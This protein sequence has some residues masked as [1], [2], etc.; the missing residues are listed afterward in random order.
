MVNTPMQEETLLRRMLQVGL[1]VHTSKG[2]TNFLAV[3]A[4]TFNKLAQ[5][6]IE[7]VTN[8]R[9]DGLERWAA[10]YDEEMHIAVVALIRDGYAFLHRTEE[11]YECKRPVENCV[12]VKLLRAY[13]FTQLMYDPVTLTLYRDPDSSK[14]A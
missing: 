6:R 13:G 14:K 9:Y 10:K 1:N 3:A 5:K 8:G 12:M 4:V 2:Y 11:E 7:Y